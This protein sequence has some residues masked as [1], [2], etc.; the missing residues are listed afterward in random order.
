MAALYPTSLA[1]QLNKVPEDTQG[2]VTPSHGGTVAAGHEFDMPISQPTPAHT[3]NPTQPSSSPHPLPAPIP[4]SAHQ[5]ATARQRP[6][7]MPP[8]AYNV[9]AAASGSSSDPNGKE[10][11]R[12]SGEETKRQNRD[13]ARVPS[14][15][16]RSSNRIL[17]DYTLS[18]T[19]GAG[20]MGKV[21]LATHNVT[22]E[23]VRFQ[24]QNSFL[25]IIY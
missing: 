18:K 3:N 14:K 8:Q 9:A 20:S 15:P 1:P 19:L 11:G 7:S 17:G 13:P 16:T 12:T 22:G 5:P 6:I 4:R 21:K 24:P 10:R 2:S 25:L 23:K